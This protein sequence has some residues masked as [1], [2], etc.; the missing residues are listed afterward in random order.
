MPHSIQYLCT[1]AFYPFAFEV[2]TWSD[3]FYLLNSSDK[4]SFSETFLYICFLIKIYSC[5]SSRC[6]L[7]YCSWVM[8]ICFPCFRVC[9]NRGQWVWVW[10][11]GCS[12]QWGPWQGSPTSSRICSNN[13]YRRHSN[14][15]RRL[16]ILL[17]HFKY[18][19]SRWVIAKELSCKCRNSTYIF[20]CIFQICCSIIISPYPAVKPMCTA[21][22]HDN[23]CG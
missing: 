4:G 9:S 23:C 1:W 15:H 14:S 2:H 19:L 16:M 22:R 6:E 20:I 17:G 8:F 7:I 3:T 10:G 5:I 21:A 11:L 13:P 12:S 18:K